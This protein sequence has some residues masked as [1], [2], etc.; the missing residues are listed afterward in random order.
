MAYL[1][2]FVGALTIIAF[3]VVK[4]MVFELGE[5][6]VKYTTVDQLPLKLKIGGIICVILSI[7]SITLTSS[8]IIH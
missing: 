3:L 7:A 4:K 1:T 8:L 5:T 2:G 6:E